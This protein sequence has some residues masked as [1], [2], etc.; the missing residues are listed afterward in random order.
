MNEILSCES[1]VKEKKDFYHLVKSK[2]AVF[3]ATRSISKK[4]EPHNSYDV[5]SASAYN[6]DQ[7]SAD[8]DDQDSTGIESL[9][10]QNIFDAAYPLHDV[11]I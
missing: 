1:Y 8:N 10:K 7:D 2:R 9:I 6:D 5:D 11:R 3:L 4:A